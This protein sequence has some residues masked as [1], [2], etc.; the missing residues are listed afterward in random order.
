MLARC[1][2]C[3]SADNDRGDVIYRDRLKTRLPVRWQRQDEW[4][5]AYK[6]GEHVHE[7]IFRAKNYRWAKD[8]PL[9]S[10][11]C[12]EILCNAFAPQETER[13]G[14]IRSVLRHIDEPGDVCRACGIDYC[15]RSADV[16]PVVRVA[17]SLDRDGGQMHN[18]GSTVDGGTQVSWIQEVTN[19]DIDV[20]MGEPLRG[21]CGVSNQCEYAPTTGSESS[22]CVRTNEPR[23][24]GDYYPPVT[25]RLFLDHGES[26]FG[27]RAET[28]IRRSRIKHSL[29]FVGPRI[30]RSPPHDDA[31]E[32]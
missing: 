19:A 4:R 6:P 21:S 20:Q 11:V 23:G 9:E 15:T 29:R 1:I 10:T 2:I 16:N 31:I 5:E 25:P 26:L 30:A 12:D 3:K 14:A 18:C 17:V 22:A 27:D 24:S 32:Q 8:C 7:F 13:G 28:G